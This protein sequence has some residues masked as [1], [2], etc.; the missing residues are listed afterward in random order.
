MSTLTHP[1]ATAVPSTSRYWL[2]AVIAIV[3]P[4][5]WRRGRCHEL[6]GLPGPHRRFRP[7]V[8]S[9]H[10]ERAARRGH[11]PGHVYEGTDTIRFNELSIAVTDPAG[12]P[13]DVSPYDGEMIY[14]TGDL[15]QGRAVA[16]FDVSEPGTYEI[17]VSGI[18]SG[19]L[20]IG[21][22]FSGRAL[23]GVLA[24]LAIAGLSVTAGFILWVLNLI[25]RSHRTTNNRDDAPNTPTAVRRERV[26]DP[27]P[28]ASDPPSW[29]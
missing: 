2:A 3:G 10:D 23:P 18:D 13:V 5:R 17:A 7:R 15:T 1:T 4:R 6:P 22:S 28:T 14:E 11:R 9:R 16:T 8:D 27:H 24:G 19:Q 25:K 29:R 12:N 20:V 21:E 26:H